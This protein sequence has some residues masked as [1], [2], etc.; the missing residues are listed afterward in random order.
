MSHRL[1]AMLAA[2]VA[3]CGTA[4]AEPRQLTL[5]NWSEYLPEALVRGFESSHGVTVRQVYFETDDHRDRIMVQ[6]NGRGFDLALINGVQVGAYRRQ[7]WLARLDTARMPN[8]ANL[9]AW[10]VDAYPEARGVAVPFTWGTIG[11]AYRR[12]LVS[13]PLMHWRDIFVPQRS[14]SGSILMIDNARETVAVALKALGHPADSDDLEA[15]RSAGAL[16]LEQRRHVWRYGYMTI[17]TDDAPLI[18]GRVRA[19]VAYSGDGVVLSERDAR[20]VYVVPEEGSLLWMD[21]LA[22]LSAAPE[23][24]LAEAFIDYLLGAGQAAAVA[25]YSRYATPNRAAEDLLPDAF[26]GDPR[27]YP[28]L[29]VRERSEW[30]RESSRPDAQRLRNQVF[31]AARGG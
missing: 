12:D 26:L 28:P 29:P 8:L 30:L 17:H 5:L 15:I 11:I 6:S 9:H 2:W 14:L 24:E 13:T 10:A 23:P 25:S 20:I 31:A 1:L 19:A 18:T 21:F 4:V 27:I 22:V 3:L 7:G 16:L